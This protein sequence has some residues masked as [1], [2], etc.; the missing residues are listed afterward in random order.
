M[1]EL[2][3]R[4]PGLDQ[5][6]ERVGLLLREVWT[7]GTIVGIS[8]ALLISGLITLRIRLG[9]SEGLHKVHPHLLWLAVRLLA[10]WSASALALSP[11]PLKLIVAG[12]AAVLVPKTVIAV[13][14]HSGVLAVRQVLLER[15]KS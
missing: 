4:N 5:L 14:D 8:G 6:A 12:I 9:T 10:G 1:Y 15:G 11:R 13:A 3:E 7:A 2:I